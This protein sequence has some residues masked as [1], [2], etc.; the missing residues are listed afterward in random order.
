MKF[1][2]SHLLLASVRQDGDQT[3]LMLWIWSS[4]D[5]PVTGGEVKWMQIIY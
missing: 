1:D 3:V 5:I 4:M 2:L